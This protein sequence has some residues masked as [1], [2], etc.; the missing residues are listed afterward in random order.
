MSS[1]GILRSVFQALS[2]DRLSNAGETAGVGIGMYL[3]GFEKLILPDINKRSSPGE[4]WEQ[5][6]A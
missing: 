5:S 1:L 3:H 4:R 2:T 6:E